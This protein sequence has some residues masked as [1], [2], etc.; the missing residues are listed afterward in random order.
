[1]SALTPP[2]LKVSPVTLCL[3]KIPTPRP[4]ARIPAGKTR[5]ARSTS[6]EAL[7]A[8]ADLV[9]ARPVNEVHVKVIILK[10]KK[11]ITTQH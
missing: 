7:S 8:S 10:V 2:S 5:S 3:L 9:L 4:D 1:M 6:A 11:S